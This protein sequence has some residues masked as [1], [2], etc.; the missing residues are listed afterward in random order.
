MIDSEFFIKHILEA[1]IDPKK[2]PVLP[3]DH[4]NNKILSEINNKLMQK[5][6]TSHV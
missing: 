5:F 1:H 2:Y 6:K 3:A 4:P